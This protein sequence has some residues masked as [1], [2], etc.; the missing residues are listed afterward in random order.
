ML[1]DWVL[2]LRSLFKRRAVEQELDDE[3]RFHVEQHGRVSRAPGSRARR[4]RPPGA[5][6]VRRARSD[7]GRASRRS[8]HRRSPTI[9][10][11]MCGMPSDSSGASPGFTV[12]AVLCLGLGIGVN[13]SIFGVLNSVL[14]RPMPVADPDR[15]IM[16][17]PRRTTAAFSYPDYRDLQARSR[18]ALGA[19][20]RPSRWN[21]TSTSTARASSWPR[22]SSPANYADVLGLRPSLGTLVRE[23][24][25]AGGGHQ[26]C[27]LAAPVQSRLR[28]SWA[29]GSAPNRSRTR[30]SA[31]RR[32]NS[33]ACSRRFERTSGCPSGHARGWPRYSRTG[34]A[35][36]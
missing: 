26:P 20:P 10:A 11:A 25:R 27:G 17:Q 19:R 3:L 6:R 36:D 15:L 24:H 35:S 21:P 14:L 34:K 16:R 5:T 13:T 18:V 12:L 9:S 4:G 23:R 8:R 29:G 28:T 7:Q 30:S 32:V 1:I 2:R 31:W 33:S 22:R